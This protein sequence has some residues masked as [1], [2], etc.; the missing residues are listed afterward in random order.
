LRVLEGGQVVS[1]SDSFG[2]SGNISVTANEKIVV[3]GIGFDGGSSLISSGAFNPTPSIVESF[4]FDTS[5]TG[6]AGVVSIN[7]PSLLVS[8]AGTIGVQNEG[9]GNAGDLTINAES[10]Q[11]LSNGRLS[12][13]TS[14]GQGGSITIDALT[15]FANDQA[16]IS[17]A[18]AG[19]GRGGN[20]TIDSEVIA[21]LNESAISANAVEGGGGQVIVVTDAL[22]QSPDSSITATSEAGPE[23]DG[24]VDV[25][26]PEETV[27]TDSE[28]APD[29]VEVPDVA[30]VCSG[31]AGESEFTITGR[32]GLPR[33]PSSIQQSYG[34]WR[35]PSSSAAANTE[36]NRI[37]Q[38]TQAQG[39][40]FNGD[41]TVSLTAQVPNPTNPAQRTACVSESVQNRS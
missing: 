9:T 25:R 18:A 2:N 37:P 4:G 10:L 40:V 17:A 23:L 3:D 36:L 33:S 35:S 28:I 20:I 31:G 27:R 21:L 11:V 15:L 26:T 39:W 1:R 7:T 41:G 12:A 8:N 19:G 38:V 13:V 5:L 16:T 32:G 22:L 29:V 30:V 14:G 24:N 34:G 6:E